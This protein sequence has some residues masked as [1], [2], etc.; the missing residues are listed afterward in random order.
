VTLTSYAT[1]RDGDGSVR[2]RPMAPA[3]KKN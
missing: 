2:T 1:N 3:L